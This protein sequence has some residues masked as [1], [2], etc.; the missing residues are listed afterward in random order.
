VTVGAVGDTWTEIKSGLTAGQRVVLADLSAPLP[1]SA[2][3]STAQNGTGNFPG[4]FFS[5]GGF[6]G[7]GFLTGPRAGG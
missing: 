2:T 7:G 1:S 4:R 6:G 5:G 3:Q